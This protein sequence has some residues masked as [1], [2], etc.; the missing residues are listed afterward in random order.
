MTV[1][2]RGIE[3]VEKPLTSREQTVC[4]MLT[5][6]KTS[7]EIAKDLGISHRTVEWHRASIFAKKGVRNAVD[8]VRT[9]F[10]GSQ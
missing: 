7:K 3:M 6:G 9:M 1:L 4:D 8:L 5:V 2:A 10:G